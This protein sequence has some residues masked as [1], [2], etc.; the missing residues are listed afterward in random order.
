MHLSISTCTHTGM[1]SYV[2]FPLLVINGSTPYRQF[3]RVLFFISWSILIYSVILLSGYSQM[4]Q[5]FLQIS[6][7]YR[8]FQDSERSSL[9]YIVNPCG[10][11]ILYIMC[12]L[13]RYLWFI[14]TPFS[15]GN[16]KFVF[17]VWICFYFIYKF[18][19]ITFLD[20]TGDNIIF[21]VLCL[22]YFT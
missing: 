4:I 9:C 21:I 16:H 12:L 1:Y 3:G 5:V 15:F 6:S 11:S 14:P 13:I 2:Y 18:I 10:P 7:H 8:L 19:Y 20:S 17:H 22:T